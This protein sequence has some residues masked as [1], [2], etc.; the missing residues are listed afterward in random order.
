MSIFLDTSILISRLIRDNDLKSKI[1]AFPANHDRKV[2]GTIALQEFKQ[3]VLKDALY[4]LAKLNKTKSYMQ[5]L[6]FV[7]SALPQ[8]SNRR[9]TICLL[10]LHKLLP[11]RSNDELTER[12][13]LY[14]RVLVLYGKKTVPPGNKYRERRRLLSCQYRCAREEEIHFL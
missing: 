2:T 11:G 8:Q 5:T 1:N 6:S 7:T 10:L 9:R 12:A 14:L 4:L 3:R 13:R